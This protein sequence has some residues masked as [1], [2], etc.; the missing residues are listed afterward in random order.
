MCFEKIVAEDDTAAADRSAL[1]EAYNA[2]AMEDEVIQNFKETVEKKAFQLACKLNAVMTMPRD[3][4]YK[5]ITDYEDFLKTV[6][7]GTF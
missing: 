4:V 6:V 5:I 1:L 7:D 2:V 3:L